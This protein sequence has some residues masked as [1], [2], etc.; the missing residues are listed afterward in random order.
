M[1]CLNSRLKTQNFVHVCIN[2]IS[3]ESLQ[4]AFFCYFSEP[5]TPEMNGSWTGTRIVF[6]MKVTPRSYGVA[7]FCIRLVEVDRHACVNHDHPYEGPFEKS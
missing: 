3:G 2:F 4:S 1:G 6:G 5:G 7:Q